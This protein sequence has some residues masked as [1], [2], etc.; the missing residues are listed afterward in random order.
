[1]KF[2]DKFVCGFRGGVA[3]ILAAV[4]VNC[5]PNTRTGVGHYVFLVLSATAFVPIVYWVESTFM[6]LR[7]KWRQ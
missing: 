1:M 7:A 4:T 2:T 3:G 5:L 6:K